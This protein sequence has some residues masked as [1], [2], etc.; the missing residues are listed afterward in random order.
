VEK[1]LISSAFLEDIDL[2]AVFNVK[3]KI[4]TCERR[5]KRLSWITTE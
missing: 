2:I 1:R 3:E 4:L 5:S